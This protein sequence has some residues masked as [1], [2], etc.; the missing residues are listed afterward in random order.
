V[1][2]GQDV[3]VVG[4]QDIGMDGALVTLGSFREPVEVRTIVTFLKEDRFAAVATL[5]DMH[6]DIGQKESRFPWH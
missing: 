1:R 4:H 5:H 2:R 6:R 3:D